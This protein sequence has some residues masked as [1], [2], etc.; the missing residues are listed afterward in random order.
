MTLRLVARA[1][2]RRPA[3]TLLAVGALALGV[4]GTT[5]VYSPAYHVLLEGLPFDDPDRIVTPD[6]RSPLSD[7]VDDALGPSR[8]LGALTAVFAGFAVLLSSLGIFGVRSLAVARRRRELGVRM[9]VGATPRM[10]VGLIARYGLV[11]VG[12]RSAIRIAGALAANQLIGSFLF[13]V[14]PFEPR[15]TGS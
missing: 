15:G 14:D 6:V 4:A 8:S 7:V 3:Y 13:Q 9:A 2:L 11:L 10:V 1:L 5:A 12:T